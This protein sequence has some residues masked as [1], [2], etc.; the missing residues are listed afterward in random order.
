[1]ALLAAYNFDEASGAVVDVSGNGHGFPLVG[2]TARTT[3]SGGHTAEG[4]FQTTATIDAGPSVFGLTANRTMEMWIK[5]TASVTDGRIFETVSAD[6]ESIWEFLFRDTAWHLQAWNATTFA[7]ATI[8]RPTDGLPHHLAGTYDG[9]SLRLYLDG[10]LAGGPTALTGPLRTNGT[11]LNVFHTC[12][13]TIIDDARF[14]D[15]ALSAAAIVTDM[16]TPVTSGVLPMALNTRT[17]QYHMNRKAG[18]L[19]NNVP[20][21]DAQAAANIWAGTV[22]KDLVG[23]LNIR[24]GNTAPN[25]RELAGVLNQLA[26]TVGLDVD[27]AAA[28]I[29]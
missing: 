19:V 15:T 2:N 23:A 12:P 16:N 20:T 1:M 24:A 9:T 11:S 7:R 25:W 17:L 13:T 28:N 6:T 8:T 21:R 22:G 3:G 10:V 4:L 14:Y 5:S 29:P 18:T 26:G 27:G